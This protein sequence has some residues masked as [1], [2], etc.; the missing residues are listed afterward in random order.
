MSQIFQGLADTRGS[1]YALA[2]RAEVLLLAIQDLAQRIPTQRRR[3]G[4]WSARKV[5]PTKLAKLFEASLVAC[6]GLFDRDFYAE[7]NEDVIRDGIDPLEHYLLHGGVEGRRPSRIFDGSRYLERYE[8][9][10]SAGLNPLVHYLKFGLVEGRSRGLPDDEL[11][12][13]SPP[14]KSPSEGAFDPLT[15]FAFLGDLPETGKATFATEL[16][17]TLRDRDLSYGRQLAEMIGRL[18]QAETRNEELQAALRE[19]EH[20]ETASLAEASKLPIG[21]KDLETKLYV[22]ESALIR[23]AARCDEALAAYRKSNV[24]SEE[25]AA[26]AKFL[27]NELIAG[28]DQLKFQQT[29][30]TLLRDVSERTQRE[31]DLV[32]RVLELSHS[33][34]ENVER[35]FRDTSSELE[36]TR[37]KLA[38]A[39][40]ELARLQRDEGRH[41]VTQAERDELRHKVAGLE[42]DAQRSGEQEIALNAARAEAAELA[43]RARAAQATLATLQAELPDLKVIAAEFQHNLIS[44]GQGSIFAAQLAETRDQL[45]GRIE[46]LTAELSDWR[47]LTSGGDIA[48]SA[49]ARSLYLDLLEATLTGSLT[50]DGN[51]SPWGAKN[52]DPQRRFI[53]RDWPES[54]L[55]MI[56]T[57]R[58]RN[59]RRLL[60]TVLEDGV[61]GDVL[62]AG[63]WRG[64]A[65]I[66]MRGILTAYGSS[67][68]TVWVA[69]SFAGLPPPDEDAYPADRQD[70]HHT[71]EELAVPLTEVQ[72]NFERFGLMDQRVKFLSGWFKDTLH[73]AP[74]ERLALLRLDGD[75]YGSSMETLQALYAKVAK[76]GFIVVD[77]YI[78]PPCR[79]A[80]DDF[81]AALAIEDTIHNVD[82]A[83][84]YWRKNNDA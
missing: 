42:R 36:D 5:E 8:D 31:L 59:L 68:R 81:R 80:V 11:P 76:G 20:R 61:D 84:I 26:R 44:A 57:A 52:F 2:W 58:M 27:E 30:L 23:A 40:S 3:F 72:S 56:G 69:D 33:Q 83:A 48:S 12:Q 21:D 34:M 79:Q 64:G 53:G 43:E 39:T 37:S 75:M 15:V 60:E 24:I 45:A 13:P 41:L 17:E 29:E 46:M 47:R 82:G 38:G 77:D 6:S 63:V 7:T 67:D 25:H 74:I 49:A 62:E 73:S 71:F 19:V 14:P 65:C 1:A 35:K 18:H 4:F 9:V 10:R 54:A 51:I 50:Q 22:A 78:L 55:T 32:N 28:K 70:R 66:Y 16:K